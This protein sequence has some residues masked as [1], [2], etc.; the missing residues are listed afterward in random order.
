MHAA[1]ISLLDRAKKFSS[2]DTH[3]TPNAALLSNA[4]AALDAFSTRVGG[5]VCGVM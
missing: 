1:N 2:I 5:I 4:D 3:V